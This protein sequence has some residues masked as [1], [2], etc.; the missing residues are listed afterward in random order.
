MTAVKSSRNAHHNLQTLGN[1]KGEG[2]NAIRPLSEP[3]SVICNWSDAKGEKIV[4]GKT[5]AKVEAFINKEWGTTQKPEVIR[6]RK[7]SETTQRNLDW[8]TEA[9]IKLN[10]Q[11]R[12]QKP[13]PRC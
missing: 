9:K 10:Y 12:P 13:L 11:P 2:K 1:W 8:F 3:K 6:E 7:K 4:V 5:W